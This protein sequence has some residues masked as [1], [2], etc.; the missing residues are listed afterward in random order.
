[1]KKFILILLTL[2]GSVST[3]AQRELEAHVIDMT[4]IDSIHHSLEQVRRANYQRLVKK[5]LQTIVQ[6]SKH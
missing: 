3:F 5:I 2:V 1:M 6:G 4:G